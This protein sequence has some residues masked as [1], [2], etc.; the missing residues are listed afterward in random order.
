MELAI[1]LVALVATLAVCFAALRLLA[2]E[3]D[4]VCAPGA[5]GRQRAQRVYQELVDL[6]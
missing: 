5:N 6:S 3:L 2:Y 1:L 4:C